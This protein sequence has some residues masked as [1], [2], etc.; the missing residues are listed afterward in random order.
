LERE[1]LR[2]CRKNPRQG[3]RARQFLPAS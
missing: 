3:A 2:R 1:L